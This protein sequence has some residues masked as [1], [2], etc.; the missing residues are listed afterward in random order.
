MHRHAPFFIV[1][2][3]RESVAARPAAADQL[4]R[5]FLVHRNG[6]FTGMNVHKIYAHRIHAG[7]DSTLFQRLHSSDFGSDLLI[8]DFASSRETSSRA[9]AGIPTFPS[10]MISLALNFLP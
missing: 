1:V 4:K 3:N 9:H 7:C 6:M 10:R 8:G 5:I 2:T